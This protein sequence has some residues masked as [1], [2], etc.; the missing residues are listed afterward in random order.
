METLQTGFYLDLMCNAVSLRVGGVFYGKK[1]IIPHN[2]SP[3]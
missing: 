2:A 1:M 3:A